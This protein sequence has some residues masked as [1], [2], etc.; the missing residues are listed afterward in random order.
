MNRDL[1]QT[2]ITINN[3]KPSFYPSVTT[4]TKASLPN[5]PS[6]PPPIVMGPPESSL[7]HPRI[8]IGP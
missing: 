8:T 2:I 4:I 7:H 3:H 5:H 6:Q 1:P